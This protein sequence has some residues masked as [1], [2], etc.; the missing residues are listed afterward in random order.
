MADNNSIEWVEADFHINQRTGP[1]KTVSGITCAGLGI[2]SD[3]DGVWFITHLGSGLIVIPA[4]VQTRD[5][6]A[7]FGN[8]ILALCDWSFQST[9]DLSTERRVAISGGIREIRWN[10]EDEEIARQTAAMEKKMERGDD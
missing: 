8:M 3:C 7:R 10:M 2:Y 6:A 9:H 1:D 5:E 4:Y